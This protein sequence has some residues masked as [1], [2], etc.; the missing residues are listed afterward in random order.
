MSERVTVTPD[1][2][3]VDQSISVVSRPNGDAGSRL[4]TT[5]VGG[6]CRRPSS[7]NSL[8]FRFKNRFNKSLL[9]QSVC[10]TIRNPSVDETTFLLDIERDQLRIRAQSITE[11]P[12]PVH[13]GAALRNQMNVKSKDRALEGEAAF[14]HRPLVGMSFSSRLML[15]T[16]A[17]NNGAHFAQMPDRNQ[18]H[19]VEDALAFAP[20]D[21]CASHVLD[22]NAW[23]GVLQESHDAVCG[24]RSA[25]IPRSQVNDFWC[26]WRLVGANQLRSSHRIRTFCFLP[27]ADTSAA[28]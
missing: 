23:Q 25:R 2:S 28:R 4:L 1:P 15:K 14:S 17:I 24:R 9:A 21:G 26:S 16:H 11:L 27:T 20:G 7:V 8:S 10:R 3:L 6:P 12:Q 18:Q 19:Q 22:F 13:L 5:I